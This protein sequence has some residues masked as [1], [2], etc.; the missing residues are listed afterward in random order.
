[1]NAFWSNGYRGTSLADLLDA[2]GL[3]R[4]SLYAAF[5]DKRG[6]FL[7]ALDRYIDD[8]LARF[9]RELAPGRSAIDGL[10]DCLTGYI[11]RMAGAAGR[12]GCLVVATAMELASQDAEVEARLGRFF[13]SAQGKLAQAASRAAVEQ[14]VSDAIDPESAARILLSTVE[15]VRVIA[16]T[17]IDRRVWQET[18]D[19]LLTRLL[20]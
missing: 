13:A 20:T 16:K 5:G 8:A 2:T 12:R 14:G 9:D 11:D 19:R 7:L 18:I 3:S 4:G 10:R 6:I 1:M 15:G 17:G